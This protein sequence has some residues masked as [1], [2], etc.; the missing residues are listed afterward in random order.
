LI[1]ETKVIDFL[2]GCNVLLYLSCIALD[3]L[4]RMLLLKAGEYKQFVDKRRPMV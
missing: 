1:S 2:I 4:G 3:I